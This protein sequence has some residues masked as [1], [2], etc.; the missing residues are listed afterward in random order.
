MVKNKADKRLDYGIIQKGPL[1]TWHIKSV[2]NKTSIKCY[3]R[4]KIFNNC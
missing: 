4:Y 2:L 1:K 3:F